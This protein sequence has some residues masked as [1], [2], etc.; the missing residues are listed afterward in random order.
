MRS[1]AGNRNN[2]FF[3]KPFAIVEL[4]VINV[5]AVDGNLSL[6]IKLKAS[7]TSNPSPSAATGQVYK[8]LIG[9][10]VVSVKARPNLLADVALD[11]YID[12]AFAK[13]YQ[14]FKAT[15]FRACGQSFDIS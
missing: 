7:R 12:G 11:L 8:G 9:N 3:K 10:R 6:W 2:V 1:C 5:I 14:K 13:L 4:E 15:Q